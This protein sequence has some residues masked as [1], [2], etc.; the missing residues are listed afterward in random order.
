M[1]KVKLGLHYQHRSWGKDQQMVLGQC[2]IHREIINLDLYLIP[3][4][5]INFKWIKYIKV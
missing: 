5:Q 2:Y 1:W 3:Y 4:P